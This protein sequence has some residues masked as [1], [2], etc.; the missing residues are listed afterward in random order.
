MM[1]ALKT[2]WAMFGLLLIAS[3]SCRAENCPWINAATAGGALGGTV[4]AKLVH[5]SREDV[6]CEF[7]LGRGNDVAILEIAVHTMGSP[8]QDFQSYRS[9]C[10]SA[11]TPL[12]GIGNEATECTS[13]DQRG[14]T[15]EQIVARVRDRAFILKWTFPPAGDSIRVLSR[16]ELQ[17]TIRNLAEQVAG[18]L[19]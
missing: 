1:S 11:A 17:D 18:S 13:I 14:T 4:T 8:A 10:S 3:V 12:R 7:R 6:T 2:F 19:F 16:D 9:T 15:T 5:T